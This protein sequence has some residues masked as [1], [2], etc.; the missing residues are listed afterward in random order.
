MFAEIITIGDEILIGQIVDSNSAFLA[1]ELNR[2]GISVYQVTSVQD[3]IRHIKKALS[4]AEA[5]ADIIIMTGGLGPTKD[6]ITKTTLAHYFED[7]LVYDDAVLANIKY[8]W[9]KLC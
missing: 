2:I 6:D 3:D 1:K 4:E 8:L 7:T 5:N 9:K